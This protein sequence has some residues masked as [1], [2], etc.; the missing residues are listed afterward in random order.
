MGR[1]VQ[2]NRIKKKKS[3]DVKMSETDICACADR[4]IVFE[5][6]EE[7]DE[8]LWVIYRHWK[9]FDTIF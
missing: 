3:D 8:G 9:F 7:D 1:G 5:C 2:I 4:V 6:F